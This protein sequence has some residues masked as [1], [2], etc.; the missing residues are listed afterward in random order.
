VNQPWVLAKIPV[1]ENQTVSFAPKVASACAPLYPDTP[2]ANFG[3]VHNTW[4]EFNYGPTDSSFVGTFDVSRNTRMQGD[5]ID[6][7]GSKCTSNMD[8]CV[9]KCQDPN[10]VS[11]EKGYQLDNCHASNGG[12]GGYDVVM[13][14]VGGGCNMGANSEHIEVTF[15]NAAGGY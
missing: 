15:K 3:G 10:A 4:V 6:A 8:T 2:L 14:G 9:F 5:I 7:R 1:G 13:Q 12:G 11:C